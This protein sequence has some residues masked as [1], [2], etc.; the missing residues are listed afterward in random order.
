M[1]NKFNNRGKRI[2]ISLL[3]AGGV[4][5]TSACA[6]E[7]VGEPTF[8]I[9]DWV[10]S[11]ETVFSKVTV[12]F[13]YYS[14]KGEFEGVTYWNFDDTKGVSES[15]EFGDM[16]HSKF[17]LRSI[18]LGETDGDSH[19]SSDPLGDYSGYLMSYVSKDEVYVRTGKFDFEPS[20]YV[21]TSSGSLTLGD[22]NSVDLIYISEEK[23]YYSWDNKQI[24]TM[25]IKGYISK[26]YYSK[27]FGY[28]GDVPDS[29]TS[30][31]IDNLFTEVF[32]TAKVSSTYS[33]ENM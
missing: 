30:A 31:Y 25:L 3:L 17:N 21:F 28:I 7:E 10:Y 4:L 33:D 22:E 1:K 19:Y 24:G 32:K 8:S 27:F 5:C 26:G 29:E 23:P 11:S 20:Q 13:P 18:Y 12:D 9:V 15:S 2:L 6:S 16:G 14:D